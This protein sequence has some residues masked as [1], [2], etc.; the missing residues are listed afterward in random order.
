MEPTSIH[1]QSQLDEAFSSPVYL[2]FKHSNICPTSAFAFA[3]YRRFLEETPDIKTAVIDVIGQRPLSQGVAKETGVEHASP[4]ALLLQ[5]GKVVWHASHG[6]ITSSSL[7][8]ALEQL[9]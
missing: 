2:L 6:G 9:P 8:A 1:E 4:Q 3:E 5:D 7:R